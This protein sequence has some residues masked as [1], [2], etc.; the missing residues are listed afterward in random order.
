MEGFEALKGDRPWDVPGAWAAGRSLP[1]MEAVASWPETV[2]GCPEERGVEPANGNGPR[3]LLRSVGN[4]EVGGREV[5]LLE[6]AREAQTGP[7]QLAGLIHDARNMVTAIELYC[8]LLDQPGVLVE[9]C[10]HYAG[11]LRTVSEASRRLLERLAEME[12][13]QRRGKEDREC[14]AAAGPRL[15]YTTP[16]L[17]ASAAVEDL[18]EP[19][20]PLSLARPRR[21]E[22]FGRERIVS[23]A[24]EL[25]ANLSLL[26]AVAGHAVT[27]GLEIA[28]GD[29]PV[30]MSRE[31][32]TRVLVNLTRNAAEA[33]PDGGHLQIALA[34]T[35]RALQMSFRDTGMGMAPEIADRIFLPGYTTHLPLGAEEAHGD[36]DEVGEGWLMP[37]RGL[38]LAIVRSLVSAAEGRVWAANRDD[39]Q[40]AVFTVEF[41]RRMRRG[42]GM[43]RPG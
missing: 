1:W 36:G 2:A 37:H 19:G 21:M 39:G 25:Q 42:D 5:E 18:E 28:G 9:E 27:V 41:P 30:A 12:G 29:G 3:G 43:P 16:Q 10:R 20:A 7:P 26:S 6:R 15:V 35:D 13:D 32:L 8:D 14:G 11:E 31:D 24:G 34:Q 17:V 23:L 4:V 40:G 33:M 38:G 22:A